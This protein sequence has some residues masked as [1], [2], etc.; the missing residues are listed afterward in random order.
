MIEKGY[1]D[2]HKISIKIKEKILEGDADTR[3]E[4][5]NLLNEIVR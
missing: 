4:K 1:N 2:W 3:V 5:N